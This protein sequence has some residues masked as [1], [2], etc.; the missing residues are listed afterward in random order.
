MASGRPQESCP[1]LG[2]STGASCNSPK[3]FQAWSPQ[4]NKVSQKAY[5]DTSTG[6]YLQP[7]FTDQTSPP[8][9]PRIPLAPGT[10]AVPAGAAHPTWP[11][12]GTARPGC[13]V[14]AVPGSPAAPIPQATPLPQRPPRPPCRSGQTFRPNFPASACREEC[15]GRA[16]EARRVSAVAVRGGQRSDDTGY[17]YCRGGSWRLLPGFLGK[18]VYLVFSLSSGSSSSSLLLRGRGGG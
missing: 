15:G 2:S 11:Q 5:H 10:T 1:S 4:S 17:R 18:G 16:G 13:R 8:V 7:A 3:P 6:I 14:P 9:T 12:A